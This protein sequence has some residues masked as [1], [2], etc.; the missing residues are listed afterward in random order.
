MPPGCRLSGAAGI[1]RRALHLVGDD[2]AVAEDDAAV[3]VVGEDGVVGD[4]DEGGAFDAVELE[5]EVEDV[6]A[7]GGV[8]VAGGLVG[9]DDGRAEDEGAGEGDALLLAAGELD[10]VVVH[11]VGEADAGEELAG[12]REAVVRSRR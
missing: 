10:G 1:V 7:V 6:G 11:A 5:Q 2:E 8:E 9:E 3:G 12:A 4:E